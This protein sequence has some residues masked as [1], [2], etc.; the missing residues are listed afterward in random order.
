MTDPIEPTTGEPLSEWERIRRQ[1]AEERLAE[2]DAFAERA[3]LRELLGG[4]EGENGQRAQTVAELRR[5][6]QGRDERLERL[7]A[8]HDQQQEELKQLRS[9]LAEQEKRLRDADA[10]RLLAET[11]EAD[12]RSETDQLRV[13]LVAA[14]KGDE[15]EDLAWPQTVETFEEAVAAAKQHLEHLVIPKAAER[16]LESLD[17]AQGSENWAQKAWDGLRALNEYAENAEEFSGG[18]WEWCEHGRPVYSWPATQKKLAMRESR[19]VMESRDLRAKRLF[20]IS[21]EVKGDGR[22]HMYAHLKVAE[23]GGDNIPRIYFHDDARGETG[24]VHVGFIGP[25]R[26]VPNT[27]TS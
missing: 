23:G 18:F 24:K 7:S 25:H 12:A 19:T 8:A 15:A 20:Q 26:L 2:F 1:W 17:A 22:V 10:Q 13:Q 4:D 27:K 9:R 21:R 14:H 5:Q 11:A 3:G 16:E 6:L